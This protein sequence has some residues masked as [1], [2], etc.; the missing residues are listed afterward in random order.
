MVSGIECT[1]KLNKTMFG[2]DHSR[3]WGDGDT[4]DSTYTALQILSTI[5]FPG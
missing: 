4:L 3:D 5:F 1:W 2:I